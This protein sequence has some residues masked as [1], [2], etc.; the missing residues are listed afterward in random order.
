MRILFIGDIVGTPGVS[1]LERALPCLV[2][3]EAIDLVVANAENA[4]TGSG[5]TPGVYR[6]LLKAGVAAVTLGDHIYKKQ[7]IIPTLQEDERLCKP[8][9][10]PPDAPGK[11]FVIVP[12]RDGTAVAVFCLLG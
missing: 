3:R 9:N 4:V 2:A 8:A 10:Y 7:E 1:F 11:E 5:L 12:A 6:K